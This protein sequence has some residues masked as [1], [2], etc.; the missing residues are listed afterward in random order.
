MAWLPY[1]GNFVLFA[2]QYAALESV[3]QRGMAAGFSSHAA[4]LTPFPP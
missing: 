2:G 1:S 3:V 4:A